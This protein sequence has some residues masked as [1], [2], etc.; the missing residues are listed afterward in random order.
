MKVIALSGAED[1]GKSHT[2][3]IAYSFLLR[4]GYVQVPGNFRVLGNSNNKDFTDILEKEGKKV[5]FVG[6][7]D[8]ING[9]GKSLK[10]LL[11]EL[12]LKGCDTALCAAR[13]NPRILAAIQAYPDH[14]II[15]KTRSTGEENNRIVNTHDAIV[16]IS[17]I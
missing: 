16:M 4:D 13:D 17:H 9:A 10:S 6:M 14:I 11:E 7:G 15:E 1:T 3:N 2:I 5:G 8:Y 12:E